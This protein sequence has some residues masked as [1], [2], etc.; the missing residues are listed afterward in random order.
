VE[1]LCRN[2]ISCCE[3]CKLK[4]NEKNYVV[5]DPELAAIV[6]TLKMWRHYLLGRKFELKIDH[7]RLK[8]LFEKPSLNARQARWMEFLCEFDFEV[9]L[10]KQKENKDTNALRKK[11]V[12]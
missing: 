1:S 5:H 10:V 12:S 11:I 2:K 6:H 8:Y 9:K 7:M 3:S 4:E